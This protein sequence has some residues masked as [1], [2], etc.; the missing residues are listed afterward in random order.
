MED[1]FVVFKTGRNEL[2]KVNISEILYLKANGNYT[3]I[4]T[5]NDTLIICEN[6]K[7][8]LA[9]VESDLLVK[10]NR[11]VVVNHSFVVKVK[12]G[13]EPLVQ[14]NNNEVFRPSKKYH[15]YLH[16]IFVHTHKGTIQTVKGSVSHIFNSHS[17]NKPDK[18][19]K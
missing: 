19:K 18:G 10:I 8:T 15:K 17:H 16:E 12:T 9:D 13:K 2:T 5:V 7:N 14:L 1:K 6:L 3:Y 11:S 4:K